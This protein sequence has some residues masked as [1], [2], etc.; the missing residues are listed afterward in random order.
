MTGYSRSPWVLR[1]ALVVCD[2][3]LSAPTAVIPFQ[4]NPETVTRRIEPRVTE[5]A[6]SA[7]KATRGT[8]NVLLPTETIKLTIELDATDQL[9]GKNA[10][11]GA[12][13][14][15]VGI[16]PAL[17]A[18]ELLVYPSAKHVIE[19]DVLAIAGSADVSGNPTIVLLEWG[20]PR[21]LPVR[22]TSISVTESAFD[23]L[24]NPIRASVELELCV[25]SVEELITVG[26]VFEAI[27]D[28]NLVAKEALAALNTAV[29]VTGIAATVA[30]AL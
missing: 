23:Q 17:A 11:T 24:L 6:T 22:V 7:G 26:R 5:P 29:A 21:V 30:K 13:A 16:H 27:A 15:A 10:A 1:G 19:W 3:T 9:E 28:V 14:E 12:I 18:L 2:T 20:A 8:G 4:Y 25:L